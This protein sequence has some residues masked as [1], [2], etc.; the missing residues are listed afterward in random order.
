[1]KI[2][3]SFH[4]DHLYYLLFNNNVN[5][6]STLLTRSC[7]RA[8]RPH[9]KWRI[10][11]IGEFNS[12]MT[13]QGIALNKE[14]TIIICDRKNWRVNRFKC[15]EPNTRQRYMALCA[16]T[17]VYHNH[18]PLWHVPYFFSTSCCP[19]CKVIQGT[20]IESFKFISCSWIKIL[21]HKLN[22]ELINF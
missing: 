20:S 19:N 8:C 4:L 22:K 5:I 16:I 18:V 3:D 9:N 12:T 17:I 21:N 7:R 11:N 14:A 1:M 15:F 10:P 6:Y 13:R 2:Q